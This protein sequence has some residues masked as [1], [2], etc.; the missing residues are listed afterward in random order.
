MVDAIEPHRLFLE[1]ILGF[2]EISNHL[3]QGIFISK[4]VGLPNVIVNTI[5]F[6]GDENGMIEL[7]HFKNPKCIQPNISTNSLGITHIAISVSSVEAIYNKCK[8]NKFEPF[9]NPLTS[10]DG[11]VKVFYV[12]GPENI[13]FEIVE[14]ING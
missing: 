8:E 7:L 11:K 2:R 9:S 1:K 3:E 10:V 5:K 14:E 4:L 6:C 13:L 12:K